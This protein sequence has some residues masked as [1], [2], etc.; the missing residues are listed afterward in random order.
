MAVCI[1]EAEGG[2]MGAEKGDVASVAYD[3]TELWRKLDNMSPS[4]F[5]GVP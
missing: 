1:Y 4:T 3:L 2:G 5:P